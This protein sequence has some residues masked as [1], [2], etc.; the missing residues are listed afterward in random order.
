MKDNYGNE[1][2]QLARPLPVE[3]LLLDMPA[4]F[5]VTPQYTFRSHLHTEITQFPIENRAVLGQLQVIV[6]LI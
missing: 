1:V 2:T 3:Y 6:T 4:A 5:P